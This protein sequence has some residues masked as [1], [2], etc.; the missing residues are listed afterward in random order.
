MPHPARIRST[1]KSMMTLKLNKDKVMNFH[2][3]GN[4]EI[5]K[6]GLNAMYCAI[7]VIPTLPVGSKQKLASPWAKIKKNRS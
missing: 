3:A 5:G 7:E 1:S 2:F 4:A 6:A